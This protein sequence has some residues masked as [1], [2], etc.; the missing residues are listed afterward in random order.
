[1][2]I[3]VGIKQVPEIPLVTVDS[4][5]GVVNLPQS[6]GMMNPF[7][8]YAI[9]E[10]LRLK[11]KHGGTVTALSLGG[12]D[13]DYALREALALGA[14]E[15]VHL[16]YDLFHNT[17]SIGVALAIAAG[18]KKLG[19]V[20]LVLFGKQAI[21]SDAATVPPAVGGFLNCPA[22]MFV[23]K[24][25]S[26]ADGKMQVERMTDD[27]YDKVT[28]TLP[29]VVSVVKEI[30]EPRLPSLKGKMSA[31]KKTVAALSA[32][33]LGLVP[34]NSEFEN[35][36]KILKASPPAARPK[37]EIISGASPAEVAD[38]LFIRLRENQIL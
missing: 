2:N 17:D 31:K 29:A 5:K 12:K 26:V 7:D 24:I 16:M 32:A 4:D 8:T 11:E 22:V 28:V 10:A 36:G 30:N 21:D 23:R 3:V 38:K 14:D 27:G 19:N 33:D 18:I 6:P 37:G 15:A 34:G 25:D 35:A 20:D 1:M 13:A 9:E